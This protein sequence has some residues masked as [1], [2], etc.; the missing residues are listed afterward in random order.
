MQIT[1]NGILG[2]VSAKKQEFKFYDNNSTTGSEDFV[3]TI[4]DKEFIQGFSL[5]FDRTYNEKFN[6]NQFINVHS[7]EDPTVEIRLWQRET[8][9]ESNYQWVNS[10]SKLKK[11]F[12]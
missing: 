8:D 9:H 11:V 3:N 12:I 2:A 10:I 6:F 4:D 1:I 5:I 7:N